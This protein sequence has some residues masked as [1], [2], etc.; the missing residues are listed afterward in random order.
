MTLYEKLS[1]LIGA[2]TVL[3]IS[4]QLYWIYRSFKADHER[5]KK[6]AT[7][8]FGK[9]VFEDVERCQKALF[10]RFSNKVINLGDLNE[11]EDW[12]NA[13]DLMANLEMLAAGVNTGIYDIEIVDRMFG[14]L[15]ITMNK[16]MGPYVDHQRDGGKYPTVFSEFTTMAQKIWNRRNPGNKGGEIK[17]SNV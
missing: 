12:Q 9:T 1:L 7:I 6:Q 8:E 14:S 13:R 15:I 11:D 10:R 2:V 16:K 4:A 17:H 5:R 3:V